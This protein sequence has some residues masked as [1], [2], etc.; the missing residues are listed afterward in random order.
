MNISEHTRIYKAYINR[1]SLADLR[2]ILDALERCWREQNSGN[3]GSQEEADFALHS[4]IMGSLE[5]MLSSDRQ[6]ITSIVSRIV[7]RE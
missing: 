7:N 4:V 2:I 1:T 5:R 6:N 3:R